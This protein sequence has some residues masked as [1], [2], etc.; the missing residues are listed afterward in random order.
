MPVPFTMLQTQERCRSPHAARNRFGA[1]TVQG[2]SI[3]QTPAVTVVRVV[4]VVVAVVS[5]V[6]VVSVETVARVVKVVP[7]DT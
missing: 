4:V 6:S 5:V 3:P 2:T 1:R 7:T